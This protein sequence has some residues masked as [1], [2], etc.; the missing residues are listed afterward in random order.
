MAKNLP[1]L[2]L[3]GAAL[4]RSVRVESWSTYE[5]VFSASL[6]GIPR[7]NGER[8]RVLEALKSFFEEGGRKRL[9]LIDNK[10]IT[11]AIV[12]P[13]EVPILPVLCSA[14]MELQ[15][16]KKRH[17][18]DDGP[19]YTPDPQRHTEEDDDVYPEPT[20]ISLGDSVP[21][22]LTLSYTRAWNQDLPPQ[23][24]HTA[25]TIMSVPTI[26]S[27][28]TP[29][30][31]ATPPTT[32][33]SPPPTASSN[34]TNEMTLIY[35]INLLPSRPLSHLPS[36]TPRSAS[37]HP[38]TTP[39]VQSLPPPSNDWLI[40]GKRRGTIKVPEGQ[41]MKIPILL[42]PLRA[43]W[44]LLPTVDVRCADGSTCETDYR[45]AG[46]EVL[47]I[48]EVESTTVRIPDGRP[49]SRGSVEGG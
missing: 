29:S 8:S 32:P 41:D 15:I 9:D 31:F 37:P 49:T 13:V 17:V 39:S 36:P 42:M 11:R 30:Q 28:T 2:D 40:S 16:D 19:P 46:T 45:S 25:S 20:M 14:T 47:C 22:T 35:D 10:E 12:I 38:P 26:V 5:H 6:E 27:P 43:G 23:T 4:V 3:D 24:P 48:A 34:A 1:Q 21:A 44:L 18:G 33:F 7:H